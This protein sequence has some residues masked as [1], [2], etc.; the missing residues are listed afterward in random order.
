MKAVSF[1]WC[2]ALV[3][4]L[5]VMHK[6]LSLLRAQLLRFHTKHCM[7][8]IVGGIEL[9]I[10][11][12]LQDFI[13]YCV[14]YPFSIDYFGAYSSKSNL[15]WYTLSK[16][17]PMASLV[18]YFWSVKTLIDCPHNIPLDSISVSIMAKSPISVSLYFCW[19]WIISCWRMLLACYPELSWLL[20]VRKMHTCRSQKAS[21]SLDRLET[22]LLR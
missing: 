19:V 17:R 3:I 2:A 11:V 20:T 21:K 1:W 10:I 15:H 13:C 7:S 18:R 12:Q 5:P 22:L 4:A 14:M 16:V 9:R 8:V 6:W